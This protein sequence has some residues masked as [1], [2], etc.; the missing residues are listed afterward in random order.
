L[1]LNSRPDFTRLSKG[2]PEIQFA[3]GGLGLD[4]WLLYDLHARN[5]VASSLLGMGDLSR[6]YFV[7]IP[8][9]GTP[10]AVMHGIEEAPWT[11]WPWE[12]TSYVAWRELEETLQTLLRG[13][14]R[15]AMEF[16][17]RDAVPAVDLVPA[18]VIE[19]VRNTG[20]QVVSSG[21]L[22]TRF[23]SRWS[24][25]D[26]VSHRRA[27]RILVDVAK[28]IFQRVAVAVDADGSVSEAR[29]S[30]WVREALVEQGCRSGGDCIM[31]TGVS[32]A[33]PHYAIIGEGA[34]FEKGA[35]ILLDLWG[36]ESDDSVFADQTWMAYLGTAVPER[37]AKLFA[38]VRDARDAAV[39]LLMDA[40]KAGRPIQGSDVD[41]AARAVVTD[42]GYGAF[43]IHRTGHSIDRAI[44]G[45]GPNIDNLETQEI[46]RLVPGIG[47]S[48]EPGIYIPGEIGVRTEINVFIGENG[49]EV[50]TPDMQTD[51]FTLYGR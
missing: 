10:V 34:E 13:R 14:A 46:R 15:I 41:D 29:A 44:H 39:A 5:S 38:I 45:M 11:A 40:W 51:M 19:L 37:T 8:T 22:L 48:I 9:R 2:L 49:P 3:L 23:Y 33:D 17:E 12:K 43:F 20:A 7:L 1:D 16:S 42:Q 30:E 32:A 47:F 35:V 31:A 36:K 4:G 18:G 6:R 27:S 26:L 21:D 25:S 28:N 50:T 24:A